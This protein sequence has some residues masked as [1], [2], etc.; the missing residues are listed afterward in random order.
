M[1]TIPK[2]YNTIGWEELKKQLF[3]LY[4][5]NHLFMALMEEGSKTDFLLDTTTYTLYKTIDVANHCYPFCFFEDENDD[6]YLG[7][8]I[9]L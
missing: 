7:I 4:G 5:S 2:N 1:A 8:E 6:D 9:E 3:Y